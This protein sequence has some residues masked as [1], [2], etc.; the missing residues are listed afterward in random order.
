M[1]ELDF[2]AS[3]FFIASPWNAQ[4]HMKHQPN[5]K[6]IAIIVGVVVV[7]P[8]RRIL[9]R[10]IRRGAGRI[11]VVRL[12]VVL[13]SASVDGALAKAAAE[14]KPR[15]QLAGL[16]ETALEFPYFLQGHGMRRL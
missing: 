7:D 3:K 2:A 1:V 8:L 9:L 16:R 15:A 6:L 5:T 10:K 11:G 14:R 4:H 13:S 12:S